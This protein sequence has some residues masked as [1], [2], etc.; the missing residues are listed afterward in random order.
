MDVTVNKKEV[1]MNEELFCTDLDDLSAA[2]SRIIDREIDFRDRILQEAYRLESSAQDEMAEI[3]EDRCVEEQLAWFVGGRLALRKEAPKE[4]PTWLEERP[5]EGEIR[6]VLSS[7]ETK[8]ECPPLVLIM[9]IN[10]GFQSVTVMQLCETE[11]L[12]YGSWKDDLYFRVTF[13]GP[14]DFIIRTS[15]GKV[16]AEPWNRYT[17]RWCDLE[18]ELVDRLEDYEI[19]M[20]MKATKESVIAANEESFLYQFRVTEVELGHRFSSVAVSAIMEQLEGAS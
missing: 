11:L 9:G 15:Q 14:E 13:M 6:R 3:A 12:P 5:S 7:T 20:A 1:V 17:L 18:A 2:E 8:I 10:E 4:L 19:E 16:L